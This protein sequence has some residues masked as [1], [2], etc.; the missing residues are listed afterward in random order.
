MPDPESAKPWRPLSVAEVA[1]LFRTAHFRWWI[2]GGYAIELFVGTPFR[3]HAD[4]DILVLRRDTST[5]RQLLGTLDV[6]MADPP[7]QLRSWSADETLPQHVHDVWCRPSA[8]APWCL[9]L[10]IDES[11]GDCWRP[12]RCPAISLSLDELGFRLS[13]GTPVLKPELQLFYKAKGRRPK[14]EQDFERCLPR[15]GPHQRQWLANAI[16]LAHGPDTPWLARLA[17]IATGS[18]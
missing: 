11:E 18:D 4:I 15:L 5:A 12:R 8:D 1:A 16:A 9:Q 13:S 10:M 14:D 2:A 6:W 3:T 7:G 17:D